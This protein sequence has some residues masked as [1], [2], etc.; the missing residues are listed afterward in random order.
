MSDAAHYGKVL[1]WYYDDD[2]LPTRIVLC[3][4]ACALASAEAYA[5]VE[6]LLS[7]K[8]KLEVPR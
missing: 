1:S 8:P 7:C 3:P 4:K 2:A 6:S 5:K